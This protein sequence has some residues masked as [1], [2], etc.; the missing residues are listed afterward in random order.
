MKRWLIDSDVLIEGERGNPAFGHW[1]KTPGEYAT[2]DI[3][4]AEFLLGLHAVPD[5]VKRQR[6]EQFYRDRIAP[7]PSFANEPADYATAARMAGEARRL[8]RG[9][10]GLADALLGAIA[11]RTGAMV[12]TQNL[13][14]FAAMGVPSENP[15]AAQAPAGRSEFA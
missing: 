6:G 8:G 7:I 13:K 2:A 4:R 12:A 11:L 10:P 1:I 15:L 9:R 3:I 14:D 5:P